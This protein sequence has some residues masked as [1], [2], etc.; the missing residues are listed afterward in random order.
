MLELHKLCRH[1]IACIVK[2]IQKHQIQQKNYYSTLLGVDGND[3]KSITHND[4]L[5]AGIGV[6]FKF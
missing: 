5:S 2:L 3:K 1:I 6:H 4:S